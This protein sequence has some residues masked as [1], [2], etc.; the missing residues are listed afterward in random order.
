MRKLPVEGVTHTVMVF[1]AGALNAGGKSREVLHPCRYHT[2]VHLWWHDGRRRGCV[3]LCCAPQPLG[4]Q[5]SFW[6]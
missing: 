2:Q 6:L 4:D 3:G 5:G 1:K